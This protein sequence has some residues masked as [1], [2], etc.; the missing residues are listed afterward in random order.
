MA[1]AKFSGAVN[2]EVFGLPRDWSIVQNWLEFNKD[3]SAPAEILDQK[4][5]KKCP[6]LPILKDY[7]A[8]PP[9]YWKSFPF[10]PLRKKVSS[11]ISAAALRRLITNNSAKLTGPQ[12]AR[13]YRAATGLEKGMSTHQSSALPPIV[14][15]NSKNTLEYGSMISDTVA[16]WVKSGFASG[17]FDSPPLDRFRVNC[18]MAIPQEGKVR[19]V[20]NVS[21]PVGRS[22]N[23]NTDKLKL[24]KIHM[25]SAREFGYLLVKCGQGATISKSDVCDA[26]KLIPVPIE[27]LNQQGFMWGNK[28]FVENSQIF[29]ANSAPCNFDQVNHTVVVIAIVV[30]GINGNLVIRH[31]DDVVCVAPA[32]SKQCEQ[33]TKSFRDICSTLGIKLQPDCPRHEKAFSCEKDGKVLGV[34]FD[35]RDLTWKLPVEKK[36]KC[37]RKIKKAISSDKISLEEMQSLLGNLN[38]IV[39]MCPFLKAF[40]RPLNNCLAE[41]MDRLDETVTLCR[42]AKRDLMVWAGVLNG[43][44]RL[45]VPREPVTG[46]PI[47]HKVFASDAAGLPEDGKEDGQAVAG[48]GLDEDGILI[49]AF[50]HEWEKEMITKKRDVE[51]KRFGNKT[52]FLES[53]GILAPFLLIPEKLRGQHIVFKTD[54]V[55]CVHGWDN[56]GMK[57][58]D[59]SSIILRAIHLVAAYLEIYVHVV[60]VPRKSDWEGNIAD[61][62]TRWSSMHQ[63]DAA[64]LRSFGNIRL[65]VF[66]ESWLAR[67]DLDW[68]LADRCLEHVRNM[69]RI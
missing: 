44:E 66:L 20:L 51:N 65:P 3:F 8:P 12:V 45:P 2:R 13:A 47:Y 60:H 32:K 58:D 4:F 14:V 64:L 39:L 53:V 46:P 6:E 56:R 54:N 29:G 1:M 57:E 26:Y 50:R 43:P 18:L 35:S 10:N 15:R 24:E 69:T 67:P 52:A 21:A 28:Y 55:A 40:K 61:R 48:V 22:L 19:P 7:K 63:R 9:E 16:H 49:L 5:K 68:R 11:Q 30:S 23:D 17:P 33:F 42:Q 36:N 38:N 27:E 41:A 31:L 59:Y 25:S 34:W 62:M 37:L